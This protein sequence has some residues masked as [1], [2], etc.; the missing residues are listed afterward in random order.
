MCLCMDADTAGIEAV[1]RFRD[2]LAA[3]GYSDVVR[4]SP[5]HKD[6]NEVLK[7][8]NGLS[9]IPAQTHPKLEAY[10]NIVADLRCSESS[11]YA[12]YLLS[13]G[14]GSAVAGILRE[15]GRYQAETNNSQQLLNIASLC[16]LAAKDLLGG[17]ILHQLALEYK[18]YTDKS[19]LKSHVDELAQCAVALRQST[20]VF[21]LKNLAD[22]AIRAAV[23]LEVEYGMAQKLGSQDFSLFMG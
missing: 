14:A 5:A 16:A 10:H 13:K 21:A 20:D 17:D 15:V 18:P 9:A 8:R 4:I 22:A 6:W 3:K 12:G 23:C 2:E 1:D 19:K 11:S 7:A